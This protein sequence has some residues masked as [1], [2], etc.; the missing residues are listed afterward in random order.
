MNANWKTNGL[1]R[2][3]LN[4]SN[5][6]GLVRFFLVWTTVSSLVAC[7]WLPWMTEDE[8]PVHHGVISVCL[9]KPPPKGKRATYAV[10]SVHRG[11]KLKD[12]GFKQ[13]APDGSA[14]F[15]VPM[16]RLYDVRIFHDLNRNQS[17]D[18][19]EPSGL[20]NN[21]SPAPLTGSDPAVLTM[22]FGVAGPV[23]G[24]P[25]RQGTRSFPEEPKPSLVIPPEAEPYLKH[26]PQWLQDKLLR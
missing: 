22:A 14:S 3:V 21:I 6:T 16:G 15:V 1:C 10:A 25:P 8:E 23:A 11:T 9:N 17:L 26:V 20:V 5:L 7:A 2:A 19:N 24:H 4:M 13:V 12:A 18:A